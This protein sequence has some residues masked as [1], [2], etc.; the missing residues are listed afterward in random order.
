MS[1]DQSACQE[2]SPVSAVKP[3]RGGLVPFSSSL[4]CTH[5]SLFCRT[6]LL[7]ENQTGRDQL[8]RE[9]PLKRSSCRLMQG[10]S[11]GRHRIHHLRH[12]RILRASCSFHYITGG[13]R[14]AQHLH[15]TTQERRPQVSFSASNA[16]LSILV[17]KQLSP[18]TDSPR[19]IL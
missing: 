6:L 8:H 9:S 11:P 13:F 17:N 12:I 3:P 15:F 16:V 2:S 4:L 19:P 1:L 18:S 14:D 7:E 10:L 5:K